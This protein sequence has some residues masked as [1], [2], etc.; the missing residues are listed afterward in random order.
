MRGRGMD[1]SGSSQEQ[2]A[3]ACECGD[4]PWGYI[5]CGEFLC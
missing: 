5:K 1:Y 3:G 4:E 2:M